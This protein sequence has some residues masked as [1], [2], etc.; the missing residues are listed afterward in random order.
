MLT[1]L[2]LYNNEKSKFIV[3]NNFNDSIKTA[4][5]DLINKY[6]ISQRVILIIYECQTTMQLNIKYSIKNFDYNLSALI[7]WCDL[8]SE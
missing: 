8:L 5:Y 4:F 1:T 6:T 3:A 2:F 7:Y